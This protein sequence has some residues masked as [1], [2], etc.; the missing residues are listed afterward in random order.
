MFNSILE[1]N[2]VVLNRLSKCRK[3]LLGYHRFLNNEHVTEKKLID[4][5]TTHCGRNVSGRDIICIQDTTEYNFQRHE[6]RI[7]AGELGPVGND[8]DIGFFAHPMLAI[9]IEQEVCLGFGAIE[10]WHRDFDKQD[11]HERKYQN[12]PIEEKESYRW[13]K[14]I[15]ASKKNL[16][17]ANH[18]TVIADR[19]SDIY[20]LWDRAP[21]EKTDLL[22]RCRADR[23]LYQSDQSLFQYLAQSPSLGAYTLQVRENKKAGRSKH[24]ALLELKVATVKIRRPDGLKADAPYIE[25]TAVEV[26]ESPGTVKAGEPPVHWILLTTERVESFEEGKEVVR[27]YGLRWQIEQLF[28]VSKHQGV[29]ME[30][31]QMETGKGLMNLCVLALQVSMKILQLTQAR[32]NSGAIGAEVTFTSR[33]IALLAAL[34]NK[35]EGKTEKQK[36]PFPNNSLSW[37]AWTIARM[38]GWKGYR[39]Q[40]TPGPITMHRGLVIFENMFQGWELSH[41]FV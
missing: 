34:V 11:K 39:T 28:R 6:K 37:A 16:H 35:Y 18:I 38:G 12:L 29:D 15:E 41:E 27:K 3:E 22:I 4:L 33:Q 14:S 5:M 9:D 23:R 30:S 25:L 40:S 2:T 31:S 24:E 19:E 21:D 26:Q 7:K 36:N 32:D 13:I 20:Q 1:K 10:L 8:T 17:Q